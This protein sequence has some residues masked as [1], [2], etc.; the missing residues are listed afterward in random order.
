MRLGVLVEV[1]VPV[2][3]PSTLVLADEVRV[4]VK[5]PL[6]AHAITLI[7]N[8]DPAVVPHCPDDRRQQLVARGDVLEE[9]PVLHP[10]TLVQQGV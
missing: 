9:D 10:G 8:P 5:S 2:Q 1:L 4:D 6:P 3:I 7:A